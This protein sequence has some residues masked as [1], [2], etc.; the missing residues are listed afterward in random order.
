MSE[1]EI[2]DTESLQGEE[3]LTTESTPE[4]NTVEVKI[5]ETQAT[6]EITK[7]KEELADK[8]N[9]YLR[10]VADFDNSRKRNARQLL[11]I[12]KNAA[13]DIITELLPILDDFERAFLADEAAKT[14][15]S[16]T[17]LIYNK[18]KKLLTNQGLKAMDVQNQ[19]FDTELHEAVSELPAPSRKQKGKVLHE[20]EKGYYLNEKIIRYA[21][22]VVGK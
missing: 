19:A 18:L 10:L 20:V 15:N 21:K 22:V 2:K 12:R 4:D 16:G 8:K 5:E 6:D 17:K 11:E 9:S 13:E 1:K 14:D 7:L 3:T